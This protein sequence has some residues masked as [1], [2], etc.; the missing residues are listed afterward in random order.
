MA[1]SRVPC[2]L[3][4]DGWKKRNE[5][6][7]NVAI[8]AI[9]FRAMDFMNDGYGL[10]KTTNFRKKKRELLQHNLDEQLYKSKNRHN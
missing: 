8:D 7:Y 10:C 1:E 4:R 5:T 6:T 2:N 9:S 3:V